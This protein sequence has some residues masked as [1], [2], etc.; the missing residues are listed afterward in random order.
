MRKQGRLSRP[1][2]FKYCT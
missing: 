2:I 1:W